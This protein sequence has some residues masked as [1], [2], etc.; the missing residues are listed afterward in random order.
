MRV[1]DCHVHVQPW[2]QMKPAALAIMTA[3]RPDLDRIRRALA[4]TAG[5]LPLMGGQG[6]ERAAL[7]NYVAPEVM[8][9][10]EA[11]NDWVA[12]FV[13]GHADR[14]VAVGSVHPRHT[15][16]AASDTGPL[17]EELGLR[18]L[19]LHPPHQLFAANGY[20]DGDEPLG[21]IYGTA[22]RLG[23]SLVLH[24]GTN[25]FP[26]GRQPLQRPDGGR[27]RRGGFS[28]IEAH[29]RSRGA[30]PL[31]ADRHFPRPPARERAPGPLGNPA[32]EPP[33][34][35][36]APRR[37]RREMPVGNGLSEPGR[38]FDEK[39]RGGF[40]GSAHLGL[41]EAAHSLR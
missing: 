6:V 1:F 8:G 14:L 21:Q 28:E 15:R 7:I 23:L 36:A 2:E 39:E 22:E 5:L 12:A 9:F 40:P 24:T 33:R 32:E 4:E 35:P 41:G 29:P 13:R 18:L 10:T 38:S 26:R 31:H 27:R 3:A 20:R 30:A 19:K 34:V 37:P 17:G 25:L 16:G 11:V